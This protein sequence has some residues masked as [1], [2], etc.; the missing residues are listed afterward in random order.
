[1]NDD[2]DWSICCVGMCTDEIGDNPAIAKSTG[3]FLWI[4]IDAVGREIGLY[5]CGQEVVVPDIHSRIPEDD[6]CLRH[7][8]MITAATYA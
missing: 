2:E 5:N 3:R 8:P 1:M 4:E 6:D 7:L